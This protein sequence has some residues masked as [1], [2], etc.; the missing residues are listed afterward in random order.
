MIARIRAGSRT[1]FSASPSGL[2]VP[3]SAST[4]GSVIAA[5]L[6]EQVSRLLFQE[7]GRAVLTVRVR[8][9]CEEA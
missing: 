4:T 6:E 3:D 9:D 7:Q 1:R 2:C 5:T 8:V